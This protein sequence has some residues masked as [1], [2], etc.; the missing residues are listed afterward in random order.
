MPTDPP[1]GTPPLRLVVKP[2]KTIFWKCRIRCRPGQYVMVEMQN[3][4]L[5]WT[6][7]NSDGKRNTFFW[8]VTSFLRFKSVFP[9]YRE[10]REALLWAKTEAEGKGL[11]TPG[12]LVLNSR[13]CWLFSEPL[14]CAAGTHGR[15]QGIKEEEWV[16][17]LAILPNQL[18]LPKWGSPWAYCSQKTKQTCCK[19]MTKPMV[20]SR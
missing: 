1:T 11:G 5:T 9:Q 19:T 8:T 15:Y 13:R 16:Q 3:V 20:K 14:S 18:L 6:M 2:K 4:L 10:K 17:F 7:F 12:Q